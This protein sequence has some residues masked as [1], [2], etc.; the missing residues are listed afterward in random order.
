ML[1]LSLTLTTRTII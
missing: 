1:A